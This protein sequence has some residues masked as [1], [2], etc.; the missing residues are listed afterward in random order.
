M[1]ELLHPAHKKSYTTASL[2]NQERLEG[3]QEKKRKL[4]EVTVNS[5][6]KCPE[7]IKLHVF[8]YAAAA[9]LDNS[10]TTGK[11]P[12]VCKEWQSII[13][14]LKIPIFKFAMSEVFPGNEETCERF[15]NGRL[16]YKPN[17]DND[18]G[19]IELRIADLVNSLGGTF[20]LSRCGDTGNYLSISTGYRMGKKPENAN[21][22]EIWFT[23][24]FLVENEI[25]GSARHFQPIFPASWS[26]AAPVAIFWT[27]GGW[28]NMD[29]YDCLTSE[30]MENLSKIDLYENYKKSGS[31]GVRACA[32]AWYVR[33]PAISCFICNLRL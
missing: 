22:V 8:K 7:E 21:K 28:D 20:D 4:G 15:L 18:N 9:L 25:N 14:Q 30:T 2:E 11:L 24:R 6:A 26:S 29:W 32:G 13:K 33:G 1:D 23:P 10:E 16:I 31:E 12:V 5:F 27:W 3:T 17:K 19:M